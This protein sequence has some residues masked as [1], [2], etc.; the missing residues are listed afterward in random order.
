MGGRRST[1]VVQFERENTVNLKEKVLYALEVAMN[2]SCEN[3]PKLV[4]NV[5]ILIDHSGSVR[6]DGGGASTVSAFSKTTTANIGN[7]FGCMLMQTQGNVFM[8][9]FGDK[10]ITVKEI[11]RKKGIL[12]NNQEIYKLGG[13]CGGG[14]EQGIYDFFE[15]VVKNKIRVD[16][17]IIFSDMVIGRESW[18]GRK[19]DT[20]SGSFQSLFKKFKVLNPHANVVSVDIKQTA[21]TSVFD[22][23]LGVTQVSGWSDKVFTVLQSMGKGYKDI[24][25]QIEKIKL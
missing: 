19:Y 15:D 13:T 25:A 23:A 5:A 17:V 24:I 14:T 12:K 7:L 16:N 9:L 1:S 10:L 6:G 21:G 8:G 22:K 4:G 20:S 18:Y 11:D 3:I 2:I